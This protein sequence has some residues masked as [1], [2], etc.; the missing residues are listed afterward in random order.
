MR[1]LLGALILLTGCASPPVPRDPQFL[2]AELE[3]VCAGREFF[4]YGEMGTMCGY[5][6]RH[7][8]ASLIREL[9]DTQ[10]APLVITAAFEEDR[11]LIQSSGE[12]I[13]PLL[14]ILLRYEDRTGASTQQ[15]R[16]ELWERWKRA[17]RS[18]TGPDGHFILADFSYYAR[19]SVYEDDIR[20]HWAWRRDQGKP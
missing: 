5:Y 18:N 17:C 6:L 7:Q 1:V 19:V 9:A 4:L 13:F 12:L 10:N 3:R 16:L 8:E 11:R 15:L 20:R 2:L 14:D